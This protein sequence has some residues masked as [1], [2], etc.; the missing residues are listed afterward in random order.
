M[1]R[2][3]K[4]TPSQE[5]LRDLLLLN[6]E[7]WNGLS[8]EAAKERVGFN[9]GTMN[10]LIWRQWVTLLDGKIYWWENVPKKRERINISFVSGAKLT[11]PIFYAPVTVFDARHKY[12]G[13]V[14]KN[15]EKVSV[16]KF[17][18]GDKKNRC[19]IK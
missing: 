12:I 4:L 6:L 3:K 18:E 15:G 7:Y 2:R 1:T 8:F 16:Y 5:K 11:N 13:K 10:A 19:F 14:W 9:E 17:L